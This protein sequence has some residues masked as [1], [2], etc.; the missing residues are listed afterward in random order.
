MSDAPRLYVVTDD[1]A[2]AALSGLGVQLCDLPDWIRIV[3]AIRDI[4]RLEAGARAVGFWFR[5]QSVARMAWEERKATG[6]FGAAAAFIDQ[7]DAW[8]Q[9]RKAHEAQLIADAIAA[10]KAAGTYDPFI[11]SQSAA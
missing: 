4:E 6:G 2:R 1:P 7:L 3:T 11:P 9:K 10:E 5:G 8:A